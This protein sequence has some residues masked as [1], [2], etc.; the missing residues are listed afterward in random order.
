MQ[1]KKSGVMYAAITLIWTWGVL[2]VPVIG[3]LDFANHITQ[4]AYV[5]AGASPSI[6]ALIFV[7]CS[8]DR[9]YKLS[10]LKRIVSLGS[11]RIKGLAVIFLLVP[12][13]TVLSA[14]I[15]LF[16]TST[17]VDWSVLVAYLHTPLSLIAFVVFTFIFGPLAEEIGWRG[18]LLDCFKQRSPLVYGVGIGLIWTIW[19]L[20]MFL[21]AGTYQNG[22]LA[23]G[24]FPVLCFV[25][26]TTALGVIIAETAKYCNSILAAIIF[27][28]MI[29]FTGELI[30]L[31][32]SAELVK[33]AIYIII[34]AV[35]IC[36]YY[37]SKKLI[38]S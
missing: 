28:F 23:Q 19:H 35:I 29:N 37:N 8:R 14:Y 31:S 36:R 9:D 13:V 24:F 5:L 7:F 32:I 17:S 18:Y 2:A 16:L 27:H 4:I 3:G 15:N 11:A 33:S 6:I 25:L 21:I 12:T 1:N 34:A 20:P 10:F 30:P 38:K 22:L 26:S